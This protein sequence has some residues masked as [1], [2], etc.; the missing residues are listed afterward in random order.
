MADAHLSI[1]TTG[2]I[3][4]TCLIEN[5]AWHA[6][7]NNDPTGDTYGRDFFWRNHNC[8]P[9]TIGVELEGFAGQPYTPAQRAAVKKIARWAEAKYDIKR[10]HTFDRYDGH[11]A[12]S[13]LSSSRTDPG[14]TFDWT[15]VTS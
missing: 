10:V 11:H 8:N 2:E 7:T 9:F 1:L 13:E 3:V 6:G 4:R 12:H 15:W 14:L 5:V